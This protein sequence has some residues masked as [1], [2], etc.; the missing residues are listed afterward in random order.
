MPSMGEKFKNFK[1]HEE[2]EQFYYWF[3]KKHPWCE[4]RLMNYS[5]HWICASGWYEGYG[6]KKKY[7]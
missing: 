3:I 4:A 5:V 7:Y 2:A 1:S 6:G